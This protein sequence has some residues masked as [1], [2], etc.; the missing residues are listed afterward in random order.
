MTQKPS[1]ADIRQAKIDNAK[2]RDRDLAT[3]LGISEAELVAAH[4]GSRDGEIITRINP[5]PDQ[6]MP[7]VSKLGEVMALTR[8]ISAVHERVGT[9]G[10][11]RSG[12]MRR[13]CWVMKLTCAFSPNTG[14]T[15]LPSIR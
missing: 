3:K 12:H 8:N 7:L 11:Y 2:M 15:A 10:E 1:T 13:W 9:Y 14:C 5:H 4:V 6:L